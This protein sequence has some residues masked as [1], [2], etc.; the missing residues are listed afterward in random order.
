[1]LGMLDDLFLVLQRKCWWDGVDVV[2]PLVESAQ[3]ATNAGGGNAAVDDTL[4][5]AEQSTGGGMTAQEIELLKSGKGAKIRV[6]A[7]RVWTLELSLI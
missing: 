5:K 2:V 6:W 4:L 3:S 1:M 7:R